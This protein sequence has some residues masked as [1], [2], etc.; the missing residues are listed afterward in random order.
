MENQLEELKGLLGAKL[1]IIGRIETLG[2]I[3]KHEEVYDE[4]VE[5]IVEETKALVNEG[6]V[7][8]IEE[9]KARNP[10][11]TPL[12]EF[13]AKSKKVND[14]INFTNEDD[15][16]KSAKK[17]VINRPKK[18]GS[19]VMYTQKV[20]RGILLNMEVKDKTSLDLIT[21]IF[22]NKTKTKSVYVPKK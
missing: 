20:L 2:L 11:I 5:N 22:K 10:N 21:E 8:N 7:K 6:D 14:S 12:I 17:L 19:K 18:D 9:V 4:L 1:E 15:M 16:L 13:I 3:D